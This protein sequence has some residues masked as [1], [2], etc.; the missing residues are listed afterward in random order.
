MA[1]KMKAAATLQR[2][3]SRMILGGVPGT[4][5]STGLATY[6]KKALFIDLDKRFPKSPALIAKTNFAELEQESYKGVKGYLNDILNESKIENDMV[7]IDTGTK[8]LAYLEDHI[9]NTEYDGKAEKYHAYGSGTKHLPKFIREITD[10]LEKIEDK[11]KVHVAIVCHTKYSPAKNPMGEDFLKNSLDL[12]TLDSINRLKQWADLVGFAYFEL[13]VDD[14]KKVKGQ[15]KRMVTFSDSPLHD[16]K[17]G[18]V[19]T[20]PPV[21]PFDVEGKWA[22]L[23]F[24]GAYTENKELVS[25]IDALIASYP[26][27]QRAEIQGRFDTIN[28]RTMGTK[29][30]KPYLDAAIAAKGGK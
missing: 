26:I 15:N 21:I 20:L 7:V 24:N 16:A 9:T 13:D 1:L 28:Y 3:T 10:L 11:H 6:A 23:V 18:G 5:K 25:Q 30:L 22:Q 29:E 17:N 14:K 2:N 19:H 12:P 27:A 4:G 8:L